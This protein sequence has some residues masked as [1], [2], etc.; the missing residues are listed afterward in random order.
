MEK[1][2]DASHSDSHPSHPAPVPFPYSRR[3]PRPHCWALAIA[4]LSTQTI[5]PVSVSVRAD[6]LAKVRQAGRLVYGSDKEGGGPYAYPDPDA[7][8]EVTGFEVELMRAIGKELGV[9]PVFAQGQ[10]DKLLQVLAIGRIDL[11]ANG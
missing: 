10:W 1:N 11:V 9:T 4:L 8:R 3:R 6:T 2:A 5:S 7:P